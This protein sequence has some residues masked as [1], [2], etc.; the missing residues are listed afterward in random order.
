MKTRSRVIPL[1]KPAER[2]LDRLVRR[3]FQSSEPLPPDERA[4]LLS[5][6]RRL[7]GWLYERY[8]KVR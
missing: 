5:Q 8:R 6:A 1:R 3:L 4:R 7:H 2:W